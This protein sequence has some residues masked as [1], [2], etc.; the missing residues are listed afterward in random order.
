MLNRVGDLLTSIDPNTAIPLASLVVTLAT[1]VY[2]ARQLRHAKQSEERSRVAG[3]LA[4][5]VTAAQEV[6]THIQA[7]PALHAFG[8]SEYHRALELAEENFRTF[9]NLA[10]RYRLMRGDMGDVLRGSSTSRTT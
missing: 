5:M 3:V 2:A 9:K 7:R 8:G 4:E 6:V 10:M 1:V